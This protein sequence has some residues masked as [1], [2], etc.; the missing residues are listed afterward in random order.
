MKERMVN[1]Y[2]GMKR[3]IT[4]DYRQFIL[5]RQVITDFLSSKRDYK[6]ID[7]HNNVKRKQVLNLLTGVLLVTFGFLIGIL[8]I[9]ILALVWLVRFRSAEKN[10]LQE[11]IVA[12]DVPRSD[13]LW[14]KT[15]VSVNRT[16]NFFKVLY[17]ALVVPVAGF[18]W[19]FLVLLFFGVFTFGI[20]PVWTAVYCYL[21]VKRLDDLLIEEIRL[22]DP[23]NPGVQLVLASEVRKDQI[24][25]AQQ[26][27]EKDQIREREQL[28]A[29]D[30]L[31]G[32]SNRIRIDD[33]ADLVQEPRSSL[34]RK[35]LYWGKAYPI[36][37]DG[38]FLVIEK[39]FKDSKDVNDFSTS[40]MSKLP[41]CHDCG[42]LLESDSKYCP[43]C[44]EEAK[45]CEIC[46]RNI[47]FGDPV[48]YCPHCGGQVPFHRGHLLETVKMMKKCP[49]CRNE[50]KENEVVILE[51]AKKK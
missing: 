14:Q 1:D 25:L 34:I 2:R 44:G 33:L 40:L 24:Q 43:S 42:E 15:L 48:A 9:W 37:I 6:L 4:K 10:L 32:M 30:S 49:R 20:V 46:K 51:M 16:N 7:A 23:D 8:V 36:R 17:L 19:V 31:I 18:F 26:L 13:Y 41:T 12:F 35:L 47:N 29:L 27:S 28:E 21:A 38:D 39:Q 3:R 11:W 50:I 45:I 22:I 5:K